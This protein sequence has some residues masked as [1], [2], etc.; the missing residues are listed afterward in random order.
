MTPDNAF[1]ERF[2]DFFR[3]LH[4]SDLSQLRSLYSDDVVFRGPERQGRGL[5]LLE[6]YYA[7]MVEDM[8]QCRY[9]FLDQLL[10]GD[11]AYL[12]WVLHF[13]HPRNRDRLCSLRGV[14]HFK[15]R[16]R[17]YFQEEFYDADL[18]LREQPAVFGNVARWIGLRRAS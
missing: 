12:K 17:I 6:D 2:K 13:R 10:G 8:N 15:W 18:A 14:S 7:S 3:A 1:I 5:V 11:S 16:D 9:E 4:D